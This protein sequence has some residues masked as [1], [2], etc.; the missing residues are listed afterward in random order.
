MS[1]TPAWIDAMERQALLDYESDRFAAADKGMPSTMQGLGDAM[2][3]AVT[4]ILAGEDPHEADRRFAATP[5]REMMNLDVA[6]T[7][8]RARL[9]SADAEEVCDA[10]RNDYIRAAKV[11]ESPIEKDLLPWLIVADWPNCNTPT[12]PVV[13]T[14]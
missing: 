3:L 14:V 9:P 10:A 6:L 11:A 7:H 2:R 1:E 5:V 13:R 4:S 12:L 8:L